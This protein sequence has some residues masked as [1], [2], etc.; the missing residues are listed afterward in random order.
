M[1]TDDGYE[2]NSSEEELNNSQQLT[3]EDLIDSLFVTC[4]VEKLGRIPVSRLI[5]YLKFTT[6]A[7]SEV[8][9]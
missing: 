7:I 8:I 5:E 6:S 3:E 4:D 1:A 2:M 9:L